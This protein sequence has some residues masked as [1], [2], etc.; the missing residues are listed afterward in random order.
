MLEIELIE[1]LLD[2][3]YILSG[4]AWHWSVFMGPKEDIPENEKSPQ[5][6]GEQDI[7]LHAEWRL[8]EL[9]RFIASVLWQMA[10]QED[11]DILKSNLPRIES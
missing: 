9:C 3:N 11:L 4:T 1:K 7:P 8:H 2:A 5:R 6:T 10:Y